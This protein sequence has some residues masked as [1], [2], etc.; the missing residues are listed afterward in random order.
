MNDPKRR[1]ARPAAGA[2][3][4]SAPNPGSGTARKKKSRAGLV[5]GVIWRLVV[6]LL[7]I[8]VIFSSVVAVMMSM[9]WRKNF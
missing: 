2:S 5:W 8:A 6:V 9:G 1:P 4:A 3:H 7:S